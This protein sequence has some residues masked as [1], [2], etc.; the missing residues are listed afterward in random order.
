M[1]SLVIKMDWLAFLYIPEG[2]KK[3]NVRLPSREEMSYDFLS[4]GPF[5]ANYLM[6]RKQ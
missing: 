3:S 6:R 2:R 5:G 4:P 1:G